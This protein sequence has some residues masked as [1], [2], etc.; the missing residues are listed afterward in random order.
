MI[1][2]VGLISVRQAG[3]EVMD[4]GGLRSGDDRL[5]VRRL[6]EAR[7]VAGDAAGEQLDILGKIA[8]VSAER[9]R[10]P[11]I[12]ACSIEAHA[13]AQRRPNADQRARER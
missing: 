7:D 4:A 8:D 13:P 1:A 12:E 5:S 2:D 9:F 11:L 6:L 10:R 3:D